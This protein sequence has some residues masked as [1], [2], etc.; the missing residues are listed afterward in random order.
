MYVDPQVVSNPTAVD[1]I[2]LVWGPPEV[3]NGVITGKEGSNL[4]KP[5]L[6]NLSIHIVR[7]LT[8]N[9]LV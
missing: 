1:N 3:P 6:A 4:T 7:N 8:W 2:V 5:S 9:I